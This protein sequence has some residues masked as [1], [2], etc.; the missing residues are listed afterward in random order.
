MRKSA[1]RSSRHALRF[2]G[3]DDL[4]DPGVETKGLCRDSC[5]RPSAAATSRRQAA[6][7]SHPPASA[8][9]VGNTTR[10]SHFTE[11]P[12]PLLWAQRLGTGRDRPEAATDAPGKSRATIAA[13]AG[14]SARGMAT[15]WRS[16]SSATGVGN[17][18]VGPCN[19]PTNGDWPGAE[20][21]GET[22][23][24]SSRKR[25]GM[26]RGLGAGIRQPPASARSG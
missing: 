23:W 15:R 9:W 7:A 14:Q 25:R 20:T 12:Y 3:F 1:W 19:R 4:Q 18:P 6:S 24:E 26:R 5:V 10:V 17:L 8:G 13:K 2:D 21:R 16:K 11:T 22:R